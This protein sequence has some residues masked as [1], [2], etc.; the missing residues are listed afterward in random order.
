M[1]VL[2]FLKLD[3][4]FFPEVFSISS[5]QHIRHM[6]I[7]SLCKYRDY[8]AS[9]SYLSPSAFTE[10]LDSL[11]GCIRRQR[12]GFSCSA[13]YIRMHISEVLLFARLC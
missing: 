12:A 13:E 4:S 1:F 3:S 9:I 7:S 2:L 5:A 6:R 10:A 8:I 11:Y